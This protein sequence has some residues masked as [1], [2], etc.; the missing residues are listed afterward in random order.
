[1]AY[2]GGYPVISPVRCRWNRCWP[3]RAFLFMPRRSSGMAA[4]FPPPALCF[5]L[6]PVNF[7]GPGLGSR[8]KFCFGILPWAT[9]LVSV[10]PGG[11]G[12]SEDDECHRAQLSLWGYHRP[13][14]PGLWPDAAG[15]AP[16]VWLCPRLRPLALSQFSLWNWNR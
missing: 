12:G 5:H 14:S 11:W 4:N 7:P 8:A 6:Q 3:T 15:P 16:W 2:R 10:V 1:M 13:Q 9:V